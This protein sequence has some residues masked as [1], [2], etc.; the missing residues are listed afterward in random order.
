ME[1]ENFSDVTLTLN[2]KNFEVHRAILA[3]RSSVFKALFEIDMN[4]EKKTD[5]V[6]IKE[7]DCEAFVELLHFIYTGKVNNLDKFAYN[8]FRLSD[9]YDLRDLK[10]ICERSLSST[11]K[12]DNAIDF[13]ILA[14]LHGAQKL[15][16]SAVNFI[17]SNISTLKDTL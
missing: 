7:D 16:R 14:E 2:G 6:E 9:K 12:F 13:L 3:A 15:K 17:V 11:L 10:R 5:V 1:N 4:K 8:L